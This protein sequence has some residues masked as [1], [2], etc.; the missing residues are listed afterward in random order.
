MPRSHTFGRMDHV[1]EVCKEHVAPDRRGKVRVE[2][3]THRSAPK[4]WVW[5]PVPCH[6]D[7][8]LKMSTPYDDQIGSG[9]YQ[10]TWQDMTAI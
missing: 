5:G 1:C 6:P 3:V 7:C 9:D 8:R 4:A 2:G 10:L